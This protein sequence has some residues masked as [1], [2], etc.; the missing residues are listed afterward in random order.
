MRSQKTSPLFHLLRNC[1]IFVYNENRG[2]A[3]KWFIEKQSENTP[4]SG[5]ILF[6]KPEEF[7]RNLRDTKDF[8]L[9]IQTG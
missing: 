8:T 7:D 4:I 1:N 3:L 2:Y 9:I 6:A 5:Q